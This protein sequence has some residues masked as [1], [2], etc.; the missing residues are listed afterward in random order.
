[1]PY[2]FDDND[3]V[4]YVREDH[5]LVDDLAY[6]TLND[7]TFSINGSSVVS[8]EILRNVTIILAPSGDVTGLTDTVNIATAKAKIVTSG[9]GRIHFGP[10]KFYITSTIDLTDDDVLYHIAL[11]GSGWAGNPADVI[12]HGT[13][14]V[15]LADNI[16]IVRLWGAP[17]VCDICFYYNTQQT[18]GQT[19]SV[20]IQLNNLSGANITDL[21]V[22]RANISYGIPQSAFGA[23]SAN[24]IFNTTLRNLDSREASLTHYDFRNFNGGGTNCTLDRLYVNGGGS[25]DFVTP[26]QSCSY[27]F[28]FVNVS[29]YEIGAVSIDGVI[30][31]ERIIDIPGGFNMIS[32]NT[33]RLEAVI[34]AKDNEGWI[35]INGSD[36]TVL[37][38]ALD[39]KNTRWLPSVTTAMYIFRTQSPRIV[40]EVNSIRIYTDC[41]FGAT[42][43]RR[44]LLNSSA[45]AGSSVKLNSFSDPN[46]ELSD[47]LWSDNITIIQTPVRVW[48]GRFVSGERQSWRSSPLLTHRVVVTTVVPTTGTWAVD[49][50]IVLDSIVNG[51]PVAYRCIT[52][53]TP[54]TWRQIQ[55]TV[56]R[57]TTANRPVPTASDVGI[58]YLDNTLDVDGKPIWWNGSAW[59]DATGAVV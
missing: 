28:R 51:L 39:I 19:S 31:N 11:T 41:E 55:Q 13:H 5:Y 24:A 14:V 23:S 59:I 9:G 42:G 8:S 22:W 20:G 32:I 40:L 49:D 6:N 18:I 52:A 34:V 7:A 57:D 43:L 26:G 10:G 47:S 29:G 30:I 33:I 2:P 48:N 16:P 56:K 21:R 46:P 35:V 17:N 27:A 1:M 15:M 36:C 50:E 53:G 12:P 25:L 58:V 37:I 45:E 54:G 4:H 38:N 3:K 44:M